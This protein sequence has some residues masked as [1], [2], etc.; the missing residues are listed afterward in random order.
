MEFTAQQIAAF[1]GGTVVGDANA[2]VHA[3]SKIEEA[4]EGSLTFLSNPKYTP[5]IY[6]T[7][8][9]IVLVN[10]DFE[11]EQPIAAT[12]IK[13]ANAYESLAKLMTLYN[14]SQPHSS[15]ISSLAYVDKTAHIAEGVSIAPFA[16]VGKDVEIGEGTVLNPHVVIYDGCK[17]GAHCT[18]HAGCVI[19]ADGFGFAPAADGYDKIPQIGNV[20][21]EDNVEIGANTCVDRATMGSTVI[22]KGA[23]LDNLIQVAH[24]V[25]IGSNTVMAAQSGIAGSTKLGEWCMIGGGAGITG[26]ITIGNR[27]QA[28]AHTGITGNVKDGITVSGYPHM[29]QHKFRRS[30]AALRSLPEMMTELNQL[31][32]EVEQ[33]KQQLAKD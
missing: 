19:G 32:K 33:L 1:V 17:I 30:Y 23:K 24:N 2:A 6:S 27:V 20:V 12:L 15:G 22:H 13:T 26:H 3:F 18:L 29:E 31:K 16:Y 5:Y 8:A 21:I 11:P 25:V 4:Q 14:A 28:G 10:N 7:R 9:T